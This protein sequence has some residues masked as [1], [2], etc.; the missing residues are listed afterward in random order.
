MAALSPAAQNRLFFLGLGLGTCAVVGL[1]RR[2]LVH[3][4]DAAALP[5]SENKPQYITQEVEDSLRLSTL[6]KL[7]DSP[8]FCIQETTSI[9]ICER[10]IHDGSTI[11]IIL[12]HITRQDYDI[13]ERGV[14][15]LMYMMNSA[16][17]RLINKPATYFALVKAL[18][19]CIT[20]YKH[21]EYDIE[22]DN[23][24]LRDAVEQECL[25]ILGQLVDKF[26][27]ESLV[28]ARFVERWLAK[29]PW[30]NDERERQINFLESLRTRNQL[31][32]LTLP[33][34]RDMAGRR[35]LCE[36][37]LLP[38]DFEW[39]LPGPRDVR[40]INGEGT[41]GED[42]GVWVEGRRRRDQSLEEEHIRRR[43]REAMVLNDGTRPLGR[44][45]IIQRER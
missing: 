8:N 22:W 12:A 44:D 39:D 7:L 4:R 17:I 38:Q 34:I 40:M 19:Y 37:K 45:D 1:M 18:E 24:Q 26:G 2:L 6:D 20:D 15:T 41:S 30:G 42:P 21:N 10:A 33:L 11:D 5:P 28:K 36:V 27:V 25:A 3:Y 29:E 9:I 31:N 35:K 32:E 16:T 43:H 13:R 14:R 23:W